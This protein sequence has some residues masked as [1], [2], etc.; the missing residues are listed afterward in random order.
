MTP[1][2][3]RSQRGGQWGPRPQRRR[4]AG[5]AVRRRLA[6]AAAAA[7]TTAILTVCWGW[8]CAKSGSVAHSRAGAAAGARC[9][10]RPCPRLRRRGGWVVGGWGLGAVAALQSCEVWPWLLRG[11]ERRIPP[12][13]H[14]FPRSAFLVPFDA[15]LKGGEWG[16]EWLPTAPGGRWCRYHCSPPPA[17]LAVLLVQREK[18]AA[19]PPWSTMGCI[20]TDY[21]VPQKVCVRVR[22][23]AAPA[24]SLP[25]RAPSPAAAPHTAYLSLAHGRHPGAV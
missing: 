23:H 1:R 4:P 20:L 16:Q 15:L 8:A 10:A 25:H 19:P 21:P 11:Q 7:T 9:T 24:P 5:P 13:L 17:S 18:K 12:E 22:V 3:S 2:A 14:A 6:P